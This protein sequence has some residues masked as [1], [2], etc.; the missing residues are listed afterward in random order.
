MIFP[1]E[2][3]IALHNFFV[4]YPIEVLVLDEDKKVIEVKKNFIPFTLWNS[5][6]QGKYLIELGLKES[7]GKV[8]VGDKVEIV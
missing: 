4:F 8:N 6:K 1:Q 3:K 7:K 5:Q 2:M